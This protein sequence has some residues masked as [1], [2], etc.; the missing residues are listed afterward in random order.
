M[1][2]P[3][4]ATELRIHHSTRCSI[5]SNSSMKNPQMG[6]IY[7][8]FARSHSRR[9]SPSNATALS[10]LIEL[11]F[12][13]V[14]NITL[15]HK[16]MRCDCY[17]V[18]P[19]NIRPIELSYRLFEPSCGSALVTPID[20]DF[21]IFD[22]ALLIFRNSLKLSIRNVTQTWTTPKIVVNCRARAM[23]CL[24]VSSQRQYPMP[25]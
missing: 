11:C 14:K 15:H 19:S 7:R 8:H 4:N 22:F 1:L 18:I 2:I 23:R 3:H 25:R 13:C 17:N 10:F 20:C 24:C 16:K 21:Y 12:L 5:P 6:D 9:Y